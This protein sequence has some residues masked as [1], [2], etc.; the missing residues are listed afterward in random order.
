MESN[1]NSSKANVTSGSTS[2]HIQNSKKTKTNIKAKSKKTSKKRRRKKENGGIKSRPLSVLEHPL[3]RSIAFVFVVTLF[4]TLLAIVSGLPL[5]TLLSAILPLSFLVSRLLSCQI[6][7]KGTLT[8]LTPLENYWLQNGAYCENSCKYGTAVCLLYVEK[9]LTIGQLRDVIYERIIRK[10]EYGRFRSKIVYKG[11]SRRPYWLRLPFEKFS[12]DEHIFEDVQIHSKDHLKRHIL[13]VSSLP[14]IKRRP[15]WQIRWCYATYLGQVVL[16]LRTHQSMCDGIGLLSILVEQLAD[17][18]PPSLTTFIRTCQGTM[19]ATTALFKPRFG[20]IN[21]AVNVCRAIIVGPLTFFLWL[22][23][24]FTRR[25]NNCLLSRHLDNGGHKRSSGSSRSNSISQS[26]VASKLSGGHLEKAA[27]QVK[28]SL[29]WSSVG[30]P[31]VMRVKQVTRSCLNDI[32]MAALSGA[33]RDYMVSTGITNPPDINVSIPVDIRSL[34][35]SDT[36]NVSVNYVLL[37]SP[38]PTGTEGSIP[39]LWEI[40]HLMEE[41]KA[42]ADPA[43]MFG[44][45]Y[46]MDNLLPACISRWLLN[47]VHR[48]SSLCLSNLQGPDMQLTIGTHRILKIVYAMSPPPS[49]PIAINIVTYNHRLF[50]SIS[51]NSRLI[52]CAKKLSKLFKS[53]LN[54]LGDLLAK[55]RVPGERT[56]RRAH[57]VIIE[58]PVGSGGHGQYYDQ[59]DLSQPDSLTTHELTDRLRQVQYDLNQLNDAL[60]RGCHERDA[61]C[62]RL[63]QLKQEFSEIMKQIRRRKSIADH[64]EIVI[65]IQNDEEEDEIDDDIDGDLRP[66]GRRFS[67]AARRPSVVSAISLGATMT[68]R[69]SV[70]PPMLSRNTSTSPESSSSPDRCYREESLV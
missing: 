69:F 53:Q 9:N 13:E 35:E 7:T 47:L 61:I 28:R 32:I 62:E 2:S 65:S 31:G 8:P 11:L 49:I 70:T 18:A 43:V 21:F 40:R 34:N 67:L 20:G 22:L 27:Y 29:H 63:T 68:K 46:F 58:A 38:L 36:E 26:S 39:R 41:L 19:T 64:P 52:D 30:L 56:K 37:T 23:W 14:L 55:R 16:I 15:L 54:Q 5:V 45:H 44:G 17:Q 59:C 48:N 60:D 25:N 10:P 12:I 1:L 4:F 50:Y 66:V 57:H 3:D 42:S 51:T 6:R 33:V 24:S